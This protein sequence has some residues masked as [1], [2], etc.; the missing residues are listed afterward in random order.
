ME[1]I[2]S[3]QASVRIFSTNLVYLMK[4]KGVLPGQLATAINV[5]P[6]RVSQWLAGNCYPKISMLIT[7]CNYFEFYDIYKLVTEEFD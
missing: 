5:S 3:K 4:E 2:I 7:L 6:H 1:A